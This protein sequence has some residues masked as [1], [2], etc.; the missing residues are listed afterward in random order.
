MQYTVYLH[1]CR[2]SNKSYI[3]WAIVRENQTPHDAMMRRWSEH[4]KNAANGLDLVISRA[5][6]KHGENEWDHEVLDALM[7]EEAAKHAEKLWITQRKTCVI[8][9]PDQ[10]YNMTRGG[11][12]G[13]MLGHVPSPEH[14][15]NLS[16]ALMGKPKS[17]IARQ[18]MSLAK[19]GKPSGFLGKQHSDEWKKNCSGENCG[20]SKLT[21]TLKHEIITRWQNRTNIPVTQYKLASDYGV[22]QSTICRL[23]NGKTWKEHT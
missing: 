23:V 2:I 7:T 17:L 4:C 20:A 10:G 9:F 12:G 18:N 19:K 6:I 8:D 14:R 3:G 13:G 11:D 5:I 22:T 15:K 16:I 1:K 21:E